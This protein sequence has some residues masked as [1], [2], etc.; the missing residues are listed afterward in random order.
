M[1]YK[2]AVAFAAIAIGLPMAIA[3]ALAQDYPNKS[4]RMVT[5]FPPGGSVGVLGRML[6]DRLTTAWGQPVIVEPKPS[7]GGLLATDIV[8]K[9]PPDGYNILMVTAN[10]TISASLYKKLPYDTVKDL[11]PIT[12]MISVPNVVVVRSDLSVNNLQELIAY[13]KKEPGKLNYS[14]GGSGSF[15]HL[16]ME[17]LKHQAGIDLAHIPYKGNAPALLGLLAKDVDLMST[18]IGDVV[19][20]IQAGKVRPIAVMSAV[21]EPT[22]PNV[23]TVAEQGFP[24]FEASGWMGMLAPAG[25]PKPIIDKL[26]KELVAALRSEEMSKFLANQGFSVIANSPGEFAAFLPK[27][28]KRWADAVKY[29]GATAD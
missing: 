9:S 16:A 1:R 14:S 19:P 24:G 6:G 28:L 27:D 26:N 25:T 21:R 5:P 23:P 2:F 13:A 17:L 29:S 15:P 3:P 22:L 10:L 11:A 20:H 4:L 7:A 18:N 12:Q 8:A